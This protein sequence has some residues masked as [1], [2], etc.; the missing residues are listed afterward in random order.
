MLN[1]EPGLIDNADPAYFFKSIL[2]T[3]EK[4]WQISSSTKRTVELNMNY[5]KLFFFV[6]DWLVI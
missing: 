4:G 5:Y 3:T 2:W 1:F 6:N